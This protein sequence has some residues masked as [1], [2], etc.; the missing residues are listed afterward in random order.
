[1]AATMMK[2]LAAAVIAAGF[3]ATGCGDDHD[4]ST[5]TAKPSAAAAKDLGAFSVSVPPTW[6]EKPPASRMRKA[7]WT[8]PGNAEL[9]VYYFGAG[10]VG[11]IEANL[12]RWMGQ[13]QQPDGSPSKDHATINDHQL[14]GFE[15]VTVDLAGTYVA[16]VRP[17]ASERLHKDGW[18]MLAA[19]VQTSQGPYYFKL[20]GPD[21]AVQAAADDFAAMIG[22]IQPAK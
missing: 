15:I 12:S 8:I 13:F 6:Q 20:L 1:M 18:R 11:G 16:A 2:A 9:V 21:A 19:I 17:G 14:R 7:Q 3:L 22:S 10:G 5:A 4:T